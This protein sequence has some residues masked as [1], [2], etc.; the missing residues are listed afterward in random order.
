[1][2]FFKFVEKLHPDIYTNLTVRLYQHDYG[3][4]QQ[5]RWGQ[6]FPNITLDLGIQMIHKLIARS[7]L[8]VSTYNAATYLEAFTMDIPTVIFWNCNHWEI[9]NSSKPYF[10]LGRCSRTLPCPM[11]FFELFS[12]S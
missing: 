10:F 7:R 4:E 9:R 2:S 5:E 3:W 1:M 11:A 6:R 12:K 8:Y